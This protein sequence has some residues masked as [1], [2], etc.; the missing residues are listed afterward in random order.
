MPP[1]RPIS[2]NADADARRNA[3]A[4]PGLPRGGARSP[5]PDEEFL[6][7]P[8]SAGEEAFPEEDGGGY[9]TGS[10]Y[11]VADERLEEDGP[12]LE[13]GADRDV[14]GEDDPYGEEEGGAYG[15]QEHGGRSFTAAEMQAAGEDGGE[16]ESFDAGPDATRAGPPMHLEII[17]G[18]DTGKKKRFSGVRMVMGRTPG[19]EL[20]LSD[21]SVSRRHA[22]LIA[23]PSGLVLRD[24]GSGN[25]TRVNDERIGEQVLAHGDVIAIGKTRLRFHDELAALELAREE[26]ERKAEEK[27]LA[28]EAA[29]AKAAADAEARAKAEAEAAEAR[30]KREEELSVKRAEREAEEAELRERR[31]RILKTVGGTF[32]TLLLLVVI[33]WLLVDPPGPS[34]DEKVAAEKMALAQKAM[35]DGEYENAAK[36]IRSAIILVAEIDKEGTLAIA[37]REAGVDVILARIRKALDEQRFEDARVALLTIPEDSE[38]GQREKKALDEERIAREQAVLVSVAEAAL[39]ENELDEARKLLP[40]LL[41]KARKA[42]EKRI[43]AIEDEA[44]KQAAAQASKQAALRKADARRYAIQ[45]RAY[46]VQA[47][48]PVSLKFHGGDY[49][50]AVLDSQRVVEKNPGAS[51]VLARARELERLIPRFATQYE[52]GQ[53]KISA[54]NPSGAERNLRKA[55]ELYQ[56]I[57]LPGPLGRKLDRALASALVASGKSALARKDLAGAAVAFRDAI[58]LD[59]DASGVRA[60]SAQVQAQAER[61][62]AD[63]VS[64]KDRRPQEALTKLR[65]VLLAAAPGSSV[66]SKA[67][68]QIAQLETPLPKDL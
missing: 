31:Q 40:F 12:A 30:K 14:Y 65:I 59:S 7:D 51:D 39:G 22:E 63:A 36:L 52:D 62:F 53:R 25:G 11:P 33:G 55:R 34:A 28:K 19:C 35:E 54:G 66:Y 1:R 50:R 16:L 23:G 48:G 42:V 64:L 21:Q 44:E 56:Q 24:L 4:T 8:A 3:A 17:E 68:S 67:Q 49:Q 43:K 46:L 57:G 18:P 2:R 13:G 60:G 58:R 29:E 27:R 6:E 26:A 20:Q 15:D 10:E 32:G 41:P 9:Q 61:L 38:R 45:R 5:P 47:F 37:Q